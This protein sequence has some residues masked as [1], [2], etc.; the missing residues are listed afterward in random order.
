MKYLSQTMT[1]LCF[2]GEKK[3]DLFFTFKRSLLKF[4]PS[5]IPSRL[6][7]NLEDDMDFPT[8]CKTRQILNRMPH[9]DHR[10]KTKFKMSPTCPCKS[11]F[12]SIRAHVRANADPD[13]IQK[14]GR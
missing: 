13:D 3:K 9:R 14:E 2:L 12:R 8:F 7:T 4:C 5:F 10:V 6:N 1:Q 11:V